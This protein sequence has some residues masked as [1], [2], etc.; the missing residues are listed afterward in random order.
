MVGTL[1]SELR[2]A[3]LR[4][5]SA[6]RALIR[7]ARREPKSHPEF[8]L[9]KVTFRGKGMQPHLKESTWGEIRDLSYQ[10]RGE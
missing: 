2:K 10:G 7:P 9:R 1:L 5:V 8:K 6:A 4:L 3:S